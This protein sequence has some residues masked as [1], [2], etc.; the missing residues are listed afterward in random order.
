MLVAHITSKY[1]RGI[2]F[3][4]WAQWLSAMGCSLVSLVSPELGIIGSESWKRS[5]ARKVSDGVDVDAKFPFFLGFL[6]F[7]CSRRQR[8]NRQQLPRNVQK[9]LKSLEKKKRNEDAKTK[10]DKEKRGKK[11]HTHTHTQT[12]CKYD[13]ET[14][15]K[16]NSLQ[17]HLHRR[18]SQNLDSKIKA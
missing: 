7:P 14:Q 13:R 6:Q 17:P 3:C 5:I 16:R 15:K 2:R 11:T 1:F 10:K 9:T 12:K 8:D 4:Q 18:P